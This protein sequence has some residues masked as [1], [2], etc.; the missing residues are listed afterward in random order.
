MVCFPVNM[1]MMSLCE[2]D[3]TDGVLHC[4]YHDDDS[5]CQIENTVM[6]CFTVDMVMIRLDVNQRV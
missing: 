5:L 2:T 6:V 4:R 1:L 3:K